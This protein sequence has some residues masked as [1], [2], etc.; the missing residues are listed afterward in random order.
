M[1]IARPP[2]VSVVT[3][4]Y[5]GDLYL[6]KCIDSILAQTHSNWEYTIVNNCSTDETLAI[7]KEYAEKDKRIRVHDNEE[8]LDVI[9]SHN[10][11]FR[12][13]SPNSKY[14]KV[15]SA[16][17]WLFP[18]CIAQMVAIADANPSV[19][20]VGSYQLSGGS[21]NWHVQWDELPY[22]STVLPGREACR[23]HLLGSNVFAN[24][25]S[26]L[27]RSD[28]VRGQQRFY[29]NSRSG[30]DTSACL[31]YLQQTDFGFVHQVLSYER[32][33]EAAV[34]A[35][36][37][38]L[39]SFIVDRLYDLIEYGPIYLTPDEFGECL[40]ST[41]AAYYQF[42]A[43]SIFHFRDKEFW[44]YHKR[45]IAECGQFSRLKLAT[46]V[47]AQVADWALN[48]KQT[49]EKVLKRGAIIN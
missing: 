26:L 34:S 9:A 35:K 6:R 38:Y 36:C 27:Y 8:F 15:V 13:I 39:N 21:S 14:C 11:A 37:R 7:A 18:E 33:H 28:L 30:A 44:N 32:N 4:V 20:I 31:K 10:L 25:T 45:S 29:P 49:V 5:N 46:A 22:P 1:R 17:D 23:R 48:P 40:N 19:S 43:T 24:P 12:L 2:L 42:L 3:P 47:C 16:D 41:L